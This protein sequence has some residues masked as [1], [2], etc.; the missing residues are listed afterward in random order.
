MPDIILADLRMPVLDGQEIIN[1]I[2]SSSLY[3]NVPIVV[4]FSLEVSAL[5]VNYIGQGE[6]PDDFIVKPFNLLEIRAR[7]KALLR[8][9][10]ERQSF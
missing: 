5:K 4:L 10:N 9:M 8:R 6:G 2:R 3:R 1:L 7:I